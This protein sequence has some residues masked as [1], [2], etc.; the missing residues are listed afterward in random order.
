[1]STSIQRLGQDNVEN[2]NRVLH[3]PTNLDHQNGNVLRIGQQQLQD[4]F[5]V[6]GATR[7]RGLERV[8]DNGIATGDVNGTNNVNNNNAN[9][10]NDLADSTRV[11]LSGAHDSLTEKVESP[12]V[13][14]PKLPDGELKVN[15]DGYHHTGRLQHL[16]RWRPSVAHQGSERH[17]DQDLR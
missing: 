9:A 1:M 5:Q 13:S 17:R 11:E 7:M 4:Q 15:P 16:Q 12:P 14:P 3:A 8:G 10:I 6:R 2:R